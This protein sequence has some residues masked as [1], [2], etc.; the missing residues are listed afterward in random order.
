MFVVVVG[1][2]L[3]YLESLRYPIRRSEFARA[4][5]IPLDLV[6][7]GGVQAAAEKLGGPQNQGSNLGKKCCDRGMQWARSWRVRLAME[8]KSEARLENLVYIAARP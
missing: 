3:W 6:I 1:V 5:S 7:L 8:E 2:A 4:G